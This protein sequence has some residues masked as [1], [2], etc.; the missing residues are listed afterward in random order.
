MPLFEVCGDILLSP[1]QTIAHGVA[2][3]ENYPTGVALALRERWPDAVADFKAACRRD[4]LKPGAIHLWRGPDKWSLNLLTQDSA[5]RK[6]VRETVAHAEYLREALRAAKRDLTSLGIT[7]IAAP[8]LCAG[9]GKMKWIEVWGILQ[10]LWGS[11]PIPVF[12]YTD[13]K[14]GVA[15]A[16]EERHFGSGNVIGETPSTRK[17]R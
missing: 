5:Q 4:H 12:V 15:C 2:P 9:H 10:E 7:S 11:L 6:D 17:R 1:A 13:Y 16:E 3:G 8:R 14:K